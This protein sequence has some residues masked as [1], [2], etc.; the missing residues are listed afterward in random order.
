MLKD[1]FRAKA[2]VNKLKPQYSSMK[3]FVFLS[4]EFP[5]KRLLENKYYSDDKLYFFILKK[6]RA[7]ERGIP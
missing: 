6:Q 1:D 3:G 7:W 4:P 5:N 2:N